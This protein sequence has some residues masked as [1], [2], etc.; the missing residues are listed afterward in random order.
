MNIIEDD[1]TKT[2][3]GFYILNYVYD[4][5]PKSEEETN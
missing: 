5:L 1:E 2:F 4:N 3:I